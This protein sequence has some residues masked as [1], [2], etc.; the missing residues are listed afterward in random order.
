VVLSGCSREE[1]E[2]KRLELQ[3]AVDGFSSK[4]AE[5]A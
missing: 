4:S 2:S 3:Q 5:R 1:A